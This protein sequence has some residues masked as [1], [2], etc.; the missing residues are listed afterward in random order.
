MPRKKSDIAAPAAEP[1][2]T[3]AVIQTSSL[4]PVLNPSADAL[5]E[6]YFRNEGFIES[7]NKRFATHMK[8]FND[9]QEVIKQQLHEKLN[10]EGLENFKTPHGTAYKSHLL[11]TK[12][13]PDAVPYVKEGGEEVRGREAV[14]DFC[15]DNWATIGNELLQIGVTKDAVKSW[16]D[17]HDG[18]PPPGVSISRFTR[19]NIRRS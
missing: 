14:L 6:E 1:A 7:E 4:A 17:S 5:V 19:I 15:L 16:M 9:R 2:P 13:D 18:A 10:A 12:I 8:P 3:Q 11:N